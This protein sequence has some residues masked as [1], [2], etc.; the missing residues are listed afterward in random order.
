MNEAI[1]N[2]VEEH[3]MI[4][5]GKG[6]VTGLIAKVKRH[7][8]E[9][10]GEGN[11]IGVSQKVGVM[12]RVHVWLACAISA[13]LGFLSNELVRGVLKAFNNP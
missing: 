11:A 2:Q 4:L 7:D 9:L 3:E 6:E 12:W 1:A 8:K 10:Y 5:H 13:V